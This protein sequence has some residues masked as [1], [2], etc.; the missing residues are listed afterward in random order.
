MLIMEALG[1]LAGIVS[2][3]FFRVQEILSPL[4]HPGIF[5]TSQA[6]AGSI[7]S[8]LKCELTQL[9]VSDCLL[10]TWSSRKRWR[11]SRASADQ[12]L[13]QSL[14]RDRYFSWTLLSFL[15]NVLYLCGDTLHLTPWF[16]LWYTFGSLHLDGFC[17]GDWFS[18][19][20]KS[21]N[22]LLPLSLWI[23]YIISTGVFFQPK[24]YRVPV[25][26]YF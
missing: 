5:Q 25:A 15:I 13:W 4:G 14:G 1:F 16:F 2:S 7:V 11:R 22:G 23:L 12:Q 10:P 8:H 9:L 26:K 17:T 19:S 20:E 18:Q 3:D 24:L 21:S 6:R